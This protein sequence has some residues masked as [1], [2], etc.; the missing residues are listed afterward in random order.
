LALILRSQFQP[1]THVPSENLAPCY[2]ENG[3]NA[4]FLISIAK[5]RSGRI[6]YLLNVRRTPRLQL[7][8]QRDQQP[9]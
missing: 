2:K 8:L 1:F 4:G 5:L 3:G 6:A 9:R 7:L